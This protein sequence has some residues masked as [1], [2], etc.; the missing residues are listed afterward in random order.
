MDPD[1]R[2]AGGS[3]ASDDVDEFLAGAGGGDR[4][5]VVAFGARDL[6][7]SALPQEGS[8]CK[9]TAACELYDCD[10]SCGNGAGY[11]YAS[12]YEGIWWTYSECDD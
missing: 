3:V 7:P 1:Q 5:D 9:S 6:C 4:L 8:S 10:L 2:R 11:A 12:C